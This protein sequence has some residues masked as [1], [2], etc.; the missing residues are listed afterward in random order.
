[1]TDAQAATLPTAGMTALRALEGE[2]GDERDGALA[3]HTLV[4]LA[5]PAQPRHASLRS[6]HHR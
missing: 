1:M 5:Q 2:D 6:D 3:E 4:L